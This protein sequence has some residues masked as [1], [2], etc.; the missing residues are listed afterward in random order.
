MTKHRQFIASA[1]AEAAA[2][3]QLK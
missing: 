3:Q 2:I 1:L